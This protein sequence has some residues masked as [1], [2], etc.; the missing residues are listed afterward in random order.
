MYMHRTLSIFIERTDF[1]RSTR[2][3]LRGRPEF[4]I[5]NPKRPADLISLHLTNHI[6]YNFNCG[7]YQ[8]GY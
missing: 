5:E 6:L 8:K 2:Y 4:I 7:N 1:C 3:Y